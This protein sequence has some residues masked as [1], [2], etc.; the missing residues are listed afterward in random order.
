MRQP[1]IDPT[2]SVLV[3]P[4]AE[5]WPGEPG[6][7]VLTL[8][9]VNGSQPWPGI[10]ATRAEAEREIASLLFPQSEPSP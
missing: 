1:V 2:R 7:V 4:A 6:F 5:L 8:C 9:P 10:H 3:R